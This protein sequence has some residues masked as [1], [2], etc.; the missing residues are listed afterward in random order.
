[1]LNLCI[2]EDAEAQQPEAAFQIASAHGLSGSHCQRYSV[3]AKEN[4][5]ERSFGQVA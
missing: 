4:N 1:M 2:Y 5:A 3:A